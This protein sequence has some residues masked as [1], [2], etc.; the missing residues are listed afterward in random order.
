[1]KNIFCRTGF[2]VILQF[3]LWVAPAFAGD[4][5]K[6][7][8]VLN[9]HRYGNIPMKYVVVPPSETD[10]GGQ[11]ILQA[12]EHIFSSVKATVRE[13][14]R[15][16]QLFATFVVDGALSASGSIYAPTGDDRS[17]LTDF[18]VA[19]SIFCWAR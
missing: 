4:I 5:D 7:R 12:S 19:Y 13:G 14:K 1:M 2:L 15:E 16:G 3:S 8:C 17:E 10:A 18:S 11:R 6:I 9:S